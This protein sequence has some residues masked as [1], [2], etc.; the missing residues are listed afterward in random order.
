M[1]KHF[2]IT[3]IQKSNRKSYYVKFKKAVYSNRHANKIEHSR[4]RTS[5]KKRKRSSKKNIYIYLLS[6]ARTKTSREGDTER[7]KKTEKEVKYKCLSNP[8]EGNAMMCKGIRAHVLSALGRKPGPRGGQTRGASLHADCLPVIILNHVVVRLLFAFTLSL[9]W[10]PDVPCRLQL[11]LLLN[12]SCCFL[13]DR[14]AN[15]TR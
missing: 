1:R 4:P 11:P 3:S 2:K 14:G 7:T 12:H 8:S 6:L 10:L 13:G 15:S 9:R 5:K